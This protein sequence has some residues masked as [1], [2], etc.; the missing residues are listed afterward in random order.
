MEGLRQKTGIT[1]INLDDF[2]WA[3]ERKSF[4]LKRFRDNIDYVQ[5][6]GFDEVYLWGVEYWY[7]LKEL[8]HLEIWGEAEGI[9]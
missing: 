1:Y 5:R 6:A 7:Y 4:N 2:R 8:G 3:V 9:F